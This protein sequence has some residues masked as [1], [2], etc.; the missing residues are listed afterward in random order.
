M[1]SSL[2]DAEKELQFSFE[3]DFEKIFKFS[4]QSYSIIKLTNGFPNAH[5]IGNILT[6][7]VITGEIDVNDLLI[8]NNRIEVPIVEVEYHNV[9]PGHRNVS[10]IIPR[11]FDDVAV[12]HELF[13]TQLKIKK[14]ICIKFDG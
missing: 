8:V 2:A 6:G 9:I 10:I 4:D 14:T 3:N 1:L 12:W 13:G 5:G 7:E 11:E